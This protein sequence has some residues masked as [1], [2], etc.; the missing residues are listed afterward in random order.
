[1]V[2]VD[3]APLLDHW[4]QHAPFPTAEMNGYRRDQ[5]LR[6]NLIHQAREIICTGEENVYSFQDDQHL[7]ILVAIDPC[8]ALSWRRRVQATI[9]H[10]VDEIARTTSVILSAGIGDHYA[11][12]SGLAHS[13]HDAK[14]ALAIGRS[15][16]KSRSVFAVSDLGLAAFACADNIATTSRLAM[17]LLCPLLVYPDLVETLY[18]YFAANLSPT[19]AAHN[20]GIHRHTLTY[21][22]AKVTEITGLNPQ[23]FDDAAQLYAAMLHQKIMPTS[24]L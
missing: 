4:H 9:M 5:L 10:L 11:E 16:D 7:V 21:R 12:L 14:F 8:D 24:R 20:L 6:R 17:Q 2:V 22:L 19:Q 23:N 18:A 15:L 1:V 3:A 13:Y